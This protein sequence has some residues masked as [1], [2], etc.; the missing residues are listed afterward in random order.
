MPIEVQPDLADIRSGFEGK[1][2]FDHF[3]AIIYDPLRKRVNDSESLLD[4]KLRVLRFID[5]LKGH[6]DKTL[7]VV[8]HE[9]TMRVF[10]AYFEGRI[11]DDQ[12]REMH[13][14]NC[15]YRQYRLNCT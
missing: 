10:I 8:A 6:K 1:L 7:V 11:E 9:D 14:G 4:Y 2:V 5:W 13:I 12:L 15:K 3:V